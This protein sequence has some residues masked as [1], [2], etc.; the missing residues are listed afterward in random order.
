MR[1]PA[2]SDTVL[3]RRGRG[4]RETN[5]GTLRPVSRRNRHERAEHEKK[6]TTIG[7]AIAAVGAAAIALGA[8]TFASFSS[9]KE[10]PDTTL[11]AG[12]L[13]FGTS[14][15]TPVEL[16][17]FVPSDTDV[18][19]TT[20]TFTNST[21]SSLSGTLKGEL[22]SLLAV[23]ARRSRRLPAEPPRALQPPRPRPV[24]HRT[25]LQVRE[26]RDITPL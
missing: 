11:A 17:P 2:L 23:M 26:L 5:A 20:M 22:G 6:K 9:T 12:K 8:G 21:G 4:G 3:P 10:G 1:S 15:T 18:E 14:S 19:T 24:R 16:G 13:D 7:V 25:P